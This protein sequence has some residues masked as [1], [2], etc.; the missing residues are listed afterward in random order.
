MVA[1]LAVLTV[2]LILTPK[3]PPTGILE[4][5]ERMPMA[6]NA[7]LPITNP[8]YPKPLVYGALID[9]LIKYESRGRIDAVGD[10]G[11]AY[12]VLQFWEQTFNQ[13]K[14]RYKMEYLSY[15][16]SEDQKLL[17]DLMIH[18]GYISQW[19]TAPKCL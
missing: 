10:K 5:L 9:C 6:G 11:K 1:F 13:F 15:K 19:T 3:S 16:S 2:G 12:G 4:A 8:Y 18:D 14:K 17:A 7:L